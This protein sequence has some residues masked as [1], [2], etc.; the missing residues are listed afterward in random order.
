MKTSKIIK[1]ISLSLLA[2]LGLLFW[3]NIVSIII[4]ESIEVSQG[5]LLMLTII[6]LLEILFV[7]CIYDF[8]IIKLSV[9]IRCLLCNLGEYFIRMKWVGTALYILR[10]NYYLL[11][12]TRLLRLG[13]ISYRSGEQN[14][15]WNGISKRSLVQLTLG[16]FRFI[17]SFPVLLAFLLAC[18]S[19]KILQVDNINNLIAI[20]EHLKEISRINI[21]EIFSI[22]PALVA[23]VTI[24]PTIFFFY[25]YS[26]KREVRKII[27]RENS[28][29]FEEVVILYK[30]LLTWIDKHIY[31]LS[32]NFDYVIKNQ[33]SIVEEFLKKQF[34]AYYDKTNKQH[35][36]SILISSFQFIKIEDL[37]E[38]QDI[39]NQLSS[40]RLKRFTRIFSIKRFDIWNLYFCNFNLLRK[41]KTINKLFF[42]KKGME[43]KISDLDSSQYDVTDEEVE[44]KRKEELSKLSRSIYDS[45]SLLYEL[46]RA[47]DSLRKYL[48]SSRTERMILKA[49]KRDK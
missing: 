12:L 15:V 48:Y 25:F 45:L 21:S 37:C 8:A 35:F 7:L 11:R 36:I 5:N 22:L 26:Q 38:L 6:Y 32:Q 30:R 34:P 41:E 31:Q 14:S 46:K 47:S 23:L 40:D 28:H 29:Y 27:D 19:L 18:L 16:I 39:I 9:Y 13:W 44:Q 43:H 33:D 4:S 42:T 49:L 1:Y 2:I 24:I 20:P 10:L 3:R 17:V